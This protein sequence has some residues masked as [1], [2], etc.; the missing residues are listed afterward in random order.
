MSE[1]LSPSGER[2]W[3]RAVVAL[4]L[5]LLAVRLA[6]A[7]SLH[8]TE[9]EAYYRLWSQAPAFGYFDHPPMIAWWIWAGRHLAGDTSL[10]VRLLPALG[11]AIVS[12]LVWDLALQLGADR[13]TA[14]RGVLWYNATL[15]AAAGGFLAVPDAPASVF[16]TACLCALA[17][18]WRGGKLR[19]WA[20]AGV[21]AGLAS[22]SKYSSLFLGPG[23]LLWLASSRGGRARLAG[24][25]PWT[26]LALAIAVFTP[27]VAW[28]ATHD[29]LT[30][31]KQFGRIAPHRFAPARLAE[32]IGEQ[33]LLLNPLIAAFLVRG[34]ARGEI[35][36]RER[37]LI[38]A[39]CAPF[40]AYLVLHALHDRVQ[41]HWPAP[42]Y[43]GAALLAAWS[44]V[45][46][47]GVWRHLRAAVPWAGFGLAA[48]ALAWVVAAGLGAA[49][50]G[51]DPARPVRDW[52]GF[53][54]RLT[55]VSSAGGA[56]WTGTT[57]YGLAAQLLDEAPLR[58]R[59]VQVA[60]RDRWAN[61]ATPRPDIGRSA[62][63]IV[64]LP[65]RVRLDLLEACFTSVQPLGM[66]AR[67]AGASRTLYAI[68][69][70][71]GPKRDV[72]G[73]GCWG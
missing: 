37:R 39:S 45:D 1:V 3:G 64:D 42:L 38:A 26:A 7:A 13:R 22:L 53:A 34:L 28:N 61:L 4:V 47:Q 11:C 16:W 58:S 15:L 43:S 62:G 54:R 25:G 17:R 6:I 50:L 21:A 14:A 23:V 41:A 31:A 65:R 71:A 66:I 9:D 70:V 67:G 12:A 44:A 36:S 5:A 30:F 29:W 2:R 52:S 19:W 32:L 48:S 73:R 60:E 40:A 59:V 72:L 27:N 51:L 49:P 33:I 10:G 56:A 68:V 35:W 24:P 18:A 57:S 69:R 8:L 63:L 46:A 20:A 55:A